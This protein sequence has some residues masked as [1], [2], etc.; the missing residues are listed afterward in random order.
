MKFTSIKYRL[1]SAIL[2]LNL[3]AIGEANAV[4]YF[5]DA[6]LSLKQLDFNAVSSDGLTN[7]SLKPLFTM[8][9]VSAGLVENRYYASLNLENS[10]SDAKLNDTVNVG[11][12]DAVARA[13]RVLTLGYFVNDTVSVFGG[14]LTGKT[15]DQYSFPT[16]YNESGVTTFSEKGPFFGMNYSFILPLGALSINVAYAF[17]NGEYAMAYSNDLASGK[18]TYTGDTSGLS[19]GAKFVGQFSPSANYYIGGKVNSFKFDSDAFQT[20]EKFYI[21]QLGLTYKF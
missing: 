15:E 8:L 12:K 9:S 5:A 10:L 11:D 2:L 13:D 4:N 14:Y 18:E 16:Q 7:Y 1:M 20:E 17:L 19:F 21:A 3:L 6:G